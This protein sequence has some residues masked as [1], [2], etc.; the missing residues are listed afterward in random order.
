MLQS[1]GK[2]TFKLPLNNL[3]TALNKLEIYMVSKNRISLIYVT[4]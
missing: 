1:K 3:S 2:N 4:S